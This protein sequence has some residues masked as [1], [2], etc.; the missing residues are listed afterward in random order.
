MALSFFKI[1]RKIYILLFLLYFPVIINAQTFDMNENNIIDLGSP[2]AVTKIEATKKNSNSSP[3]N[4]LLG[5]FEGST[6]SSFSDGF[7]IAMIKEDDVRNNPDTISVNAQCKKNIQY[8][9]YIPPNS[10]NAQFSQVTISTG[11]SS[12]GK[13]FLE[14]DLPLMVV[15]TENSKE[16]D[17]TETY[18]NCYVTII[19]ADGSVNLDNKN[20]RF[21][22]ARINRNIYKKYSKNY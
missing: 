13:N 11:G 17:S 2:T 5:I 7:P 9:R 15:K 8:I 12:T 1:Q 20:G 6:D 3:Y 22:R 19:N 10:N 4:Y 21:N 18:I 16:P 14:T